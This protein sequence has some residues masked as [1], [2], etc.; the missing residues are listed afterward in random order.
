MKFQGGRYSAYLI[1]Y[2][3]KNIPSMF[4]SIVMVTSSFIADHFAG[5]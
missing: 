2:A 4:Y 3:E 1:I 5:L